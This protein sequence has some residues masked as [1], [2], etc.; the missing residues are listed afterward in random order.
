MKKIKYLM[1]RI[2]HMNFSNMF[3]TIDKIHDITNKSKIYLFFDIVICGLKYQAGYVDYLLF[4]MWKMNSKERKT[5][6]TRGK[7]NTIVKY[8]N[9]KDYF[10][11][12][13]NKDEFNKIFNGYLNREY[14][15]LDNNEKD[16]KEFIKNKEYIF[17]KPIDGVH[18]DSIEKIKVKTFK[19]NLYKYLIEKNLRLI[20]EVIIQSKEMNELYPNSIN[21]IRVMT[22]Y[23]FDGKVDVLA[24]FQRIGNNNSVVDNYNNGGMV[25][26]VNEETGVINYPAIDKNKNIYYEHPITKTKIV[27]FKIPCFNEIIKLVKETSK[28]VKEVRYIAWDIAVT[29]K[30]PVIVEG[31]E[32]PGYDICQLPPHRKDNIGI[33]PKFEK[34]IGKIEDLK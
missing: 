29:K 19:G 25:A 24:V 30:G 26:P 23:K 17:C 15:I 4:E 18:G 28:I 27:G 7:N 14:I 33:L 6:L 13:K 2:K 21:T 8:F 10:H 5:V 12:F 16:F 11:I 3:K 32:Y 31:N 1:Q 9:N 22:I 34:S 20:E